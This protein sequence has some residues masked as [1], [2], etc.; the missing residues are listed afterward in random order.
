MVVPAVR[1]NHGYVIN[2]IMDF[3]YT[4]PS[5]ALDVV[6]T[7]LGQPDADPDDAD[8]LGVLLTQGNSA[9]AVRS[10]GSGLEMRVLPET[11]QIVER[12]VEESAM[13]GS[14]AEHL[15]EAWNLAFSRTPDPVKSYSESI[16]AVEAAA[17]PVLSP[18]NLRATL[19]TLIRDFEN[20][21]GKWE[22]VIPSTSGTDAVLVMM[23][24]LWTGQTSR[25]GGVAPTQPE[26]PEAA[27]AAVFLAASLV[28]LFISEAIRSA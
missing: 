3:V 22:F 15:T 7:L 6:E 18:K 19:G 1:R 2:K 10:D 11:R 16:K 24:T 21:P 14:V 5:N 25:H 27:Q 26:S 23:R 13:A 20:A 8:A 17:A 4:S 9:Y 12:A 28:Q